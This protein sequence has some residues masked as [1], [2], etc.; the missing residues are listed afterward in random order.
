MVYLF[1]QS[2]WSM[3]SAR[4]GIFIWGGHRKVVGF[5]GQNQDFH[6]RFRAR[7]RIKWT[8]K[9]KMGLGSK[10]MFGRGDGLQKL[11]LGS[12]LGP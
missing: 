5:C 8:Q 7:L 2:I 3:N 1:A 9:F 10:P 4:L 6:V 12:A 11:I